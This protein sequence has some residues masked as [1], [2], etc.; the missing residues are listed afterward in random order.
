MRKILSLILTAVLVITSVSA[1]C[2]ATLAEDVNYTVYET[3]SI[4]DDSSVSLPS[5]NL[6]TG[7]AYYISSSG[8]GSEMVTTPNYQGT[9]WLIN[10]L[11]TSGNLV[12][13][14]FDNAIGGG[15]VYGLGSFY[16]ANKF[17]LCTSDV[18]PITSFEVYVGNS[19]ENIFAQ[20]N[21]VAAHTRQ[22]DTALHYVITMDDGA[23]VSGKYMGIKVID[24]RDSATTKSA[25]FVKISAYGTN[26]TTFE[27][28]YDTSKTPAFQ[29][30]EGVSLN[31]GQLPLEIIKKDGTVISNP[32]VGTT[33]SG[34]NYHLLQ[35]TDG[36]FDNDIKY[37]QLTEA[38][39]GALGS[40]I[41]YDLKG[42]FNISNVLVSTGQNNAPYSTKWKLYISDNKEDL[43]TAANCYAFVE[44]PVV[45]GVKNVEKLHNVNLNEV[46]GRYVGI[47]NL[48]NGQNWAAFY[49]NEIAIYGTDTWT[50]E[51]DFEFSIVPQN[52]LLSG[53]DT[54][55]WRAADQ[56]TNTD[57][58]TDLSL[59]GGHYTV[60]SGDT[61]NTTYK[62]FFDNTFAKEIT[63]YNGHND[64]HNDKYQYD[65]SYGHKYTNAKMVFDLGAGNAQTVDAVYIDSFSQKYKYRA[66][67]GNDPATLFSNENLL[68]ISDDMVTGDT[69]AKVDAA[70]QKTGRYMGIMIIGGT[71]TNFKATEIAFYAADKATTSVATAVTSEPINA[72]KELYVGANSTVGTSVQET[73][74]NNQPVSKLTNNYLLDESNLNGRGGYGLYFWNAG[75]NMTY[76]LGAAADVSKIL[77]SGGKKLSG[78]NTMAIK[79][80]GVYMSNDKANL[81]SAEN[82]VAFVLND[83]YTQAHIFDTSSVE[84]TYRYVGFR[85]FAKYPHYPTETATS[86]VTEIFLTE[87]GIYGNF[88][89]DDYTVTANPTEADIAGLGSNGLAGATLDDTDVD[90]VVITDGEIYTDN[91][92]NITATSSESVKLT[93]KLAC[94]QTVNAVL[95][96]GAYATETV[97]AP[98]HY[99]VYASN[100]AETLFDNA[101]IDYYVA[102]LDTNVGS[103]GGMVKLFKFATSIEAEYIGIEFMTGFDTRTM[104]VAEIAVYS[105]VTLDL[106]AS[107]QI[108]D[109]ADIDSI[110][111]DGV[112]SGASLELGS[113][114]LAGNRTIVI[115]GK[116][117]SSDVY[118]A[119]DG[120]VTLKSELKN[121]L[122]T[123][124]I[125]ELRTD[126]PVALRFV[127]EVTLDAKNIANQMGTI[128]AK[129]QDLNGA[130][131]LRG[132]TDYKIA[133]AVAYEKDAKDIKCGDDT[134][135]VSHFSVA[136]H[137]INQKKYL[138]NY[139][140][141][142]YIT[143]SDGD[144][145]YTVYG[146]TVM[147]TP[148]DVAEDIKSDANASAAATAW[149][150]EVIANSDIVA[151]NNAYATSYNITAD[152]LSNAVVTETPDNDNYSP[153][154]ARFKK[155]IEKAQRGEDL[156][157][158]TIGGSITRGAYADPIDINCYANLVREWFANTFG[159]NV[160]LVN[161]GV[162]S[163]HTNLGV[164]RLKQEIL[165]KDPDIVIIEYAVNE[166]TAA[167][168]E[169]NFATYEAMVRKVLSHNDDVALLE[170]FM[171]KYKNNSDN[172]ALEFINAQEMQ[173]KIGGHYGVPMISFYDAVLPLLEED[174]VDFGATEGD[175]WNL[176]MADGIHPNNYGHKIAAT[177]I[178]NYIAGVVAGVDSITDTV[179]A[180]PSVIDGSAA[181]AYTGT[182]TLYNSVTLP[183]EYVV[184]YGSYAPIHNA[185][186]AHGAAEIFNDCW[187]AENKN[188]E[189]MEPMVISVPSGK[190]VSVLL[191]RKKDVNG[192]G[193]MCYIENN[194]GTTTKGLQNYINSSAYADPVFC[195]TNETAQ[196]LKITLSPLGDA[197]GE[198][199]LIA[200]IMITE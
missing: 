114:V 117:G 42:N 143:V 84:G 192:V 152:M 88:P 89:T 173:S 27:N 86:P 196:P 118:F 12:N 79:C 11:Y 131:L 81:Y 164:Y 91:A 115:Y 55:Y 97:F 19:R 46:T 140:V 170:M 62:P 59:T 108:T 168:S 28:L 107:A 174:Q 120:D 96:G 17:V 98:G 75:H 13:L 200:G 8:V 47:E 9:A 136:L 190:T 177:L 186:S 160:T 64:R 149:A 176:I 26:G 54:M 45:G 139:I 99:K 68:A 48:A 110:Y 50:V 171:I 116:D 109:A 161:A 138:N 162:S 124:S 3:V 63:I 127:T 31:F 130:T 165:D 40:K 37:S 135:T 180:L 132:A 182:S 73:D 21:L 137:N 104:S 148:L 102:D 185:T 58:N 14:R 61:F 189:A 35:W 2:I 142:P 119:A 82:Q 193:A 106:D 158:G 76:D 126:D 15:I 65:A 49:A 52:N 93:Y 123:P 77:I 22:N 41:T 155:L 112:E 29:Y 154:L 33:V 195:Y 166:N 94:S 80:Y 153:N 128:V 144:K 16:S 125:P 172:T 36:D 175:Y 187:Y 57:V 178:T 151:V 121:A 30:P 60:W 198:W 20:E 72:G 85:I 83:D 51:N 183:S 56:V 194:T 24:T 181:G 5:S 69:Y 78:D 133:D 103:N 105:T 159:V 71:T 111:V 134:A 156:V 100:S 1:V 146:K 197:A 66:Y 32:T 179:S 145:V 39:G 199:S 44:D 67:V 122:S 188:G 191:W 101:V 23:A 53:I 34:V 70:H 157:I 150:D 147:C 38:N 4:A 25:W 43:Y 113:D 18:N 167:V 141:R 169:A 163:T 90:N 10:G 92:V 6:L 129:W 184:S 7:T 74:G 95:V 87:F